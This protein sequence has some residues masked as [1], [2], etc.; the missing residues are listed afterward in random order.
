MNGVMVDGLAL[1][2]EIKK[3]D[4]D[5]TCGLAKIGRINNDRFINIDN[6]EMYNIYKKSKTNEDSTILVIEPNIKNF[7][8]V[9]MGVNEEVL[10]PA[11]IK[12]LLKEV[13]PSISFYPPKK[14]LIKNTK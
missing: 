5:Y 2:I 13:Y 8:N 7:L 9:Y 11:W 4:Y 14:V 10:S 6:N 1:G 3:N 12:H